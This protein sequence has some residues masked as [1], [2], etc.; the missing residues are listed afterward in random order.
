MSYTSRLDTYSHEKDFLA[1]GTSRMTI[2]CFNSLTFMHRR[3]E[4][5]KH[6]FG[7]RYQDCGAFV[8]FDREAEEEEEQGQEMTEAASRG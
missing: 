5:Q 1:F 2:F 6:G 7:W 4:K 3:F 8:R